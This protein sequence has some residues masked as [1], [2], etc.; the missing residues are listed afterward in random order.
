MKNILLLAPAVLVLLGRAGAG[1][2]PYDDRAMIDRVLASAREL[3]KIVPKA[4][5]ADTRAAEFRKGKVPAKL[6]E[7]KA[8]VSAVRKALRRHADPPEILGHRRK[9]VDLVGRLV[10][11]TEGL[12]RNGASLASVNRELARHKTKKPNC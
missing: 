8:H 1:G 6:A 12:G 7:L 11:A 5:T 3:Y 4:D 10:T 9:M 2:E